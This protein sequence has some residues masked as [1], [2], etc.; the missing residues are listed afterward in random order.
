MPTRQKFLRKLDQ[1]DLPPRTKRSLNSS[2]VALCD[3]YDEDEEE[4]KISPDAASFAR[5][6]EFLSHPYHQIWRPPAI[7]INSDGLFAAIWQEMGV[8]RWVLDFHTDGKI[9]ELYMEINA[10]GSVSSKPRSNR[11]G[12]FVQPPVSESKLR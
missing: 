8:Y 4:G 6:L 5:M 2:L 1:A 3:G 9:E 10:D 7:T 12:N 11:V